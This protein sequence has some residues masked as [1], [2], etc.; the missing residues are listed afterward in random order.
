MK[1]LSE[2]TL[3][4]A[5][6]VVK[7]DYSNFFTT[8]NEWKLTDIS[9]DM[10]EPCQ[11]LRSRDKAYVFTFYDD[12]IDLSLEDPKRVFSIDDIN[13]DSN[14]K[15]YLKAYELGYYVP[16]LSELIEKKLA[17]KAK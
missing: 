9:K 1:K 13:W 10:D 7:A 15:C 3:A 16:V 12:S 8:G 2:I 17:E 11:Q 14:Y 5:I 4:D 6:E